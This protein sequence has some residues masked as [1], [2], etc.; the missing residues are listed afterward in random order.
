MKY[1]EII[2]RTPKQIANVGDTVELTKHF[3]GKNGILPIGFRFVVETKTF[4]SERVHSN[5]KGDRY[6]IGSQTFDD[7][8]FINSE[9]YKVVEKSS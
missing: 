1:R 5:F 9:W 6:F 7:F 2:P 4:L 3:H 8:R